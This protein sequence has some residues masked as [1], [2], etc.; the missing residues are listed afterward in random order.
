[1]I[2]QK[3]LKNSRF[4]RISRA[5]AILARRGREFIHELKGKLVHPIRFLLELIRYRKLATQEA[6][7]LYPCLNDWVQ[8]TP[9]EPIYFYQDSWAFERIWAERPTRHIDIG[10]HHKY[11]ALLSKVVP[12]TMVDIRPLSCQLDSLTFLQGSILNIPFNNESIESLSSI[13]VI[14]HIGLGRY[15]DPL[16]PNG[17]IEACREI[18]RVIRPGGS[19]YVSVPIGPHAKTYFSA[20]RSFTEAQF[21]SYFPGFTL[22]DQAYIY[23]SR[24][25]REREASPGVGCFNLVKGTAASEP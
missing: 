12:G 20:H 16:N 22:R 23:G 6:I 14:E 4:S 1:M 25:S 7:A 19:V 21:L 5:P 18:C 9:I 2:R 24:L 8:A 13:C 3:R 10:S 17:S 15:G 11:V